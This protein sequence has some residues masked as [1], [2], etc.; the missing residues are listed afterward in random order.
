MPS[1]DRISA[2]H[3]SLRFCEMSPRGWGT[4][5]PT[6]LRERACLANKRE[7]KFR[8]GAAGAGA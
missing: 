4:S 5:A 8:A 3:S 2:R 7:K 1:A 6:A